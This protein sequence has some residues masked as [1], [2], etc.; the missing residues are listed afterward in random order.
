MSL[1]VSSDQRRATKMSI[2]KWTPK[3]TFKCPE[4][5]KNLEENNGKHHCADCNLDVQLVMKLGAA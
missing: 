2:T 1:E 4:C 3:M 5:A